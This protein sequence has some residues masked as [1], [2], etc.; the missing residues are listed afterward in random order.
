MEQ[1]DKSLNLLTQNGKKDCPIV[2]AGDFNC[3]HINWINHTTHSTG[4]DNDIQQSLVDIMQSST[5]TQVHHSPTRFM[6]ILDLIF[7]SNPSL[8]K[9]SV[10]VPGISDHEMIVTDAD[11]RPQRTTP[12]A[13]KC[14]QFH[15]AEWQ[16]QLSSGNLTRFADGSAVAQFGNTKV[17]ATA[18]SKKRNSPLSF[19]PMT[20]DFRQRADAVGRIPTSHLRRDLGATEMEILTSRM[21]DRSLRPMFPSSFFSDTQV[22]CNTQMIDDSYGPDI[23]S[24]NA[25][26]AALSLSDIPWDGPVGAVRVGLVDKEVV[27]NPT[28]KQ[29]QHSA[30]DLVITAAH[31]H[32]VVM[33]EGKGDAVALHDL[34]R[35][36]SQGVTQAQSIVQGIAQ[37]AQ[38]MGRPKRPLDPLPTLEPEVAESLRSLC[39]ARVRDVL[40]ND[41]HDKVSRDVAIQE[42]KADVIE[43]LKETYPASDPSLMNDSYNSMTKEIF[44]NLIL[45]EDRRCDG[46]GLQ[47]LRNINCQVDYL[48]LLHG[49]ALFQRGQTQVL[50]TLTFD[51]PEAAAKMDPVSILTGNIKEKNF[52]LHYEFPPYAINEIGRP[53]RVGRREMGHGALAEN[54][55]RAV[56]PND[57]PFTIR[58]LAEVLESNG[59]SSMA[60]VC[61]GSLALM[62]A[63]VKIK[64]PAAGVAMGLVSRRDAETGEITDSKIVTDQLGI[65]DY[66]GDMDLKMAGTR[67][68][69]TALQV[70]FKLPGVPLEIVSK[71]LEQGFASKN[72]ILDIMAETISKP[73]DSLKPH[74]PVIENL[75]VKPQHRA[76]FIGIGG[77]NFRKLRMETGVV[78]TPVDDC[79]YQL[80]APNREAI[81]EAKEM[82]EEI[83]ADKEPELD[84]GAIYKGRIVE[85][86]D[87]GVMVELHPRLQPVLLHNSQLDQR[88]VQHASALNMEEGQEITVKYFG[89]D[90]VSG[91]M[92]I[93]R[94]VLQAPATTVIRNLGSA[95][96][97]SPKS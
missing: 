77:R 66:M 25:A 2:L 5:L 44:R 32:R 28:R 14:F 78:V 51:S 42:I 24:I 79:S 97:D 7:F 76:K 55:L 52:M 19:F 72:E 69:V 59:S 89:R 63:G 46:R 92:R 41:N 27:V 16:L 36:I 49:S 29:L 37:M 47:Q 17:L 30:L 3:P 80:Y 40:Y 86:R 26:S 88:K 54:G 38:K 74:G 68:G 56:I 85:I 21:I 75:D 82:I 12:L 84:F 61:G 39:S 58:L 20:V 48:K 73:R 4:K 23:V 8:V 60:S 95:N 71:S 11:T 83:L 53:G 62:D 1:L 64:A 33:L 34:Q 65:E 70:D 94:K 87:V 15:K 35:A 81:D 10:S 90:P 91:R 96:Q 6:N 9:S 50:C 31:K 67:Y 13:K 43:K 93:S 18:I 22:S 45:D 57:F